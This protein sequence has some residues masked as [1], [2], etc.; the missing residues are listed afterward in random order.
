M[1]RRE[2]FIVIPT[3]LLTLLVGGGVTWLV[4]RHFSGQRA[5]VDSLHKRINQLEQ[6][7]QI[8]DQQLRL[9]SSDLSFTRDQAVAAQK[10]LIV[11]E[12]SV[13]FLQAALAQPPVSSRRVSPV[14]PNTRQTTPPQT[15]SR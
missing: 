12:Q 2:L 5:E 6:K 8:A 13:R 15:T 11:L 9:L 7:Q 10:K 3:V 4:A 1:P 14:Q